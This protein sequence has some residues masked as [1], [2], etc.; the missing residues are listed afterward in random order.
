MLYRLL[1][2][3]P[4]RLFCK[5]AMS[6]VLCIDHSRVYVTGESN[7]GMLAHY[8]VQS[9]PGENGEGVGSCKLRHANIYNH[10]LPILYIIPLLYSVWVPSI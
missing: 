2:D 9:L 3:C 1:L 6:A 8:L 4:W 5:E 10:D 7:G